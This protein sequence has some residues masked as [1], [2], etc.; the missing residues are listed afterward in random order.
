M[1]DYPLNLH[2]SQT[3]VDLFGEGFEFDYPLNLHIS[4]TLNGF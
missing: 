2:I 3:N 1:F 4:Q